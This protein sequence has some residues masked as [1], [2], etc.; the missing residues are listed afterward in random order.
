MV[1]DDANVVR[2]FFSSDPDVGASFGPLRVTRDAT[3]DTYALAYN[4]PVAGTYAVSGVSIKDVSIPAAAT[5]NLV[6]SPGSAVVAPSPARRRRSPCTS[7]T[8]TATCWTR[9]SRG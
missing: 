1:P 7:P 8:A 9:R 2:R 5:F 3:D 4:V 6:A